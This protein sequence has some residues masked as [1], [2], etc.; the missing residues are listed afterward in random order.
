MLVIGGRTNENLED[1]GNCID[2][3]NS[4]SSEW[5]KVNC[6]NRYRHSVI[7]IE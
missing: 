3:Y 7:T 6:L 4:E 5:S 1:L 2:I